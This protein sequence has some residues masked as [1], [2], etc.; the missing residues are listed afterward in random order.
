M[1]LKFSSEVDAPLDEVFRWHGRPGAIVRLTPPWQPV[2]I[3]AEASSLRDG[4]AKL[5]FPAGIVWNA[6]HD[7]S[8]FSPP[9]Q[10][11]D[12][13]GNPALSKIFRWRHTHYFSAGP[14]SRT[15]VTDVVET[16]VPE[17]FLRSM[18]AYRHRQLAADLA[19]QHRYRADPLTVA[20]T[21][22]SG[23][24]GTALTAF[25]TTAGHRVIRLVRHRARATDERT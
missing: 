7:P 11:V 8:G 6:L 22:A 16:P 17:R 20:V 13:L 3:G 4:H 9:H 12:R 2:R 21:G 10:F 19:A 14:E 24:V 1:G 25:L 15:T 18:F 5:I 23:L